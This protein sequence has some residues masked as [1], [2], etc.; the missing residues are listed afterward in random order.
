[1]E[2]KNVLL[3]YILSAAELLFAILSYLLQIFSLQTI[4]LC[5]SYKLLPLNF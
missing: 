1:M 5:K 4:S 3:L 2:M